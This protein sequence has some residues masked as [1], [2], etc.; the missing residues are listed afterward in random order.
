MNKKNKIQPKPNDQNSGFS[1]IEVMAAMVIMGSCLAYTMPMILYS[2]ISNSKSEA[3]AGAL[4]V[5]QKIFDN[6][7]GKTFG[8]IPDTDTTK[9]N[10]DLPLDQTTALGRNYNVAIRYCQVDPLTL[11]NPCTANYRQ[12]TITVRDTKGEQSSDNSIL[13]QTQAGFSNFN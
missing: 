8:N 13:Y 10:V 5:S 7:R 1:L 9:G 11:L 2:K 3:R 6:V 12:F 4:I